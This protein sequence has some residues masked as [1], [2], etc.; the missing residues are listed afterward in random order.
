MFKDA[1]PKAWPLNGS[2][3]GTLKGSLKGTL[4]GLGFRGGVLGLIRNSDP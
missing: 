2:L 3:E 4:L 1:R